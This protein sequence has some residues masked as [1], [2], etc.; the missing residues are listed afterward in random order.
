[1][2]DDQ[3]REVLHRAKASRADDKDGITRWMVTQHA[4]WL[5]HPSQEQ[6]NAID[7]VDIENGKNVS[8]KV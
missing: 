4:D 8:I 5:D 6:E 2:E 3:S 1:M 7:V